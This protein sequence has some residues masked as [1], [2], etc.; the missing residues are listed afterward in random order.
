MSSS[1]LAA[2]MLH[3]A[4]RPGEALTALPAEALPNDLADAYAAQAQLVGL[5]S[6]EIGPP[7]GYKVGC[8]NITAR[9]MLK[10]DFPFSGRCFESQVVSSPASIDASALHMIGIEPEIAVRIARDLAPGKV[11]T[12]DHVIEHIG[13][14]MPAIE[15]VESRFST[16]PLMGVLSAIADNG[17]HRQLVLGNEITNWSQQQVE[18]AQVSLTA[19]GRV[20]REGCA[21][22]VDGGPFAVVA[23]LANHLNAMGIT[24]MAGE[25]I[26]TGVMTDIY[27][28]APGEELHAEYNLPGDVRLSIT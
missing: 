4:R 25:V 14:V 11:W 23:W 5:L 24:L 13:E 3:Q 27:D 26:T 6:N 12:T 9:Q 20:V 1:Q 2:Q 18:D 17:V 16:W 28:S 15:I 10:L 7:I 22:N 19:N 8:T 21:T